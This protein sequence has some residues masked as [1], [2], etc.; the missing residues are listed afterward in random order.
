[1]EFKGA[2]IKSLALADVVD[3]QKTS[4]DRC[5]AWAD[6]NKA[7]FK[8]YVTYYCERSGLSDSFRANF[9]GKINLINQQQ[10]LPNIA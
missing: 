5:K 8:K 3:P 4:I 9:L 10:G 6:T 2:H 1:M 7:Q